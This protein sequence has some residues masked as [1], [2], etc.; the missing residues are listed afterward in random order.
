MLFV[1]VVVLLAGCCSPQKLSSVNVRLI[2]QHRDWWCWAASTEMIS[3]YYGHR[4]D[5]CQ[6]A[7]FVH[8]IP[9]DCCTGCTGDCPGWGG[10]WGATISDIQNNWTHWNFNYQYVASSLSWDNL[11]KTISTAMFC[12]KSPIMVVWWWKPVGWS[13]G[14]VVVAYGYAEAGGQRY[15]AYYNPLPED[16]S[17][18]GTQCTAV[19]G[20]EDA[21]TTYDAFVDDASHTW[22]NSFYDFDYTGP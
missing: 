7:N 18:V 19:P 12:C 5:Q 22:G 11:K 10:D 8:G 15:V 9:P 14:H 2:P 13:G 16:C 17:K 1:L 20:G 4:V 6:S 3:E 21:V